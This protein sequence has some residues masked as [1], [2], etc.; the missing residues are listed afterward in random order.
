MINRTQNAKR[1]SIWGLV[2]KMVM[3]LL[4]F[5]VKS[6]IIYL[7]GVEYLGISGLFT[8]IL[9]ILNITELGIGNAIIYSMYKPIA[10]GDK[11]RI[12]ELL[13]FYKKIYRAIGLGIFIVGLLLIPILPKLI[14]SDLPA[15]LNLYVI[16][17]MYLINA[18]ISYLMFSYKRCL[19][20]AH[21]REDVLS[22]VS[23]SINIVLNVAQLLLLFI[24]K[25]Y[26]FFV[27]VMPI[28]TVFH[29]LIDAYITSRMYPEYTARGR[30]SDEKKK[31]IKKQ[32]VGLSAMRIASTS[33]N[34]LDSIIVS[35]LLGLNM[36]AMHSNYFYIINSLAGIVAVLTKA[37]AAGIGNSIATEN[38]E[39]NYKDMRRLNLAYMSLNGLF[40]V[41][42]LCLYQ[43]FMRFWVGE[44]LV[45]SDG[46]MLLYVLYFY[47]ARMS[48]IAGQYFDAA[49]LWWKGKW[50][51]FIETGANL[52]LN[53]ILGHLFGVAGIILATIISAVIVNIPLTFR[54]LFKYYYKM[55]SLEFYKDHLNMLA[56]SICIGVAAYVICGFLPEFESVVGQL[57]GLALRGVI[58]VAVWACIS[59]IKYRFSSDYKE[60]IDW[61]KVRLFKR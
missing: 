47:V 16:Y 53:I 15:G 34:S 14:K 59:F 33:R 30:L 37:I 29:N 55:N 49:G 52:L 60:S 1:N 11:E 32:V 9:N 26:Y 40:A 31:E 2:N 12:C 43:P 21:Q 3:L 44:N 20:H 35:A 50:K 45:F 39:K 27:A 46:I 22:K 61:L 38:E 41:C 19:M 6:A 18:S 23:M 8:S 36:V 13:N 25:N 5:C 7:V 58:A 56:Q 24:F 54:I 10:E 48:N 17:L 28:I 51:Y 4:P 57:A 42:M